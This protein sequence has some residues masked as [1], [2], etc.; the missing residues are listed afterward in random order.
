[1]DVPSGVARFAEFELDAGRYEL[2][3]GDRVLKLE[4]IPMQL[5]TLLVEGNGQLVTRDQIIE[6]IWGKGV[7]LDTEHG[8][9]TAIRKIRLALGDNPEQPRFVQTVTGK[10]YRFI[11]PTIEI[12][13]GG[14]G[15]A[16]GADSP[17]PV[18][19]PDAIG[20]SPVLERRSRWPHSWLLVLGCALALSFVANFVWRRAHAV[21]SSNAGHVDRLSRPQIKSLAVLP[22][23]NLSGDPS[24]EYFADGMTDELIT[25]LAKNS[26]LR[27]V[28][29]TSVMQY[30]GAHRP[31]PEIARALGVDGILEGSVVRSADRVHMTVQLIQAPSDTHVWAESYDRSGNDSVSIPQEAAQ[32][33]AKRL[34]SAVLQPT[35]QRFVLPDAHDA[36]LRG[37]YLWFMSKNE[38]A[39][40]YFR[41]AIELQPDYALGWAGVSTYYAAA[42]MTATLRPDEEA[43]GQTE[44]AA[45][46]AVE[47]DDSLPEGHLALGGAYFLRWNWAL[48]EREV[49][50]AIALNPQF[51]EAYHLQ[52]LLYGVLGRPQDGIEA[53]KRSTELDPVE[54]PYAMAQAYAIA[55]DYDAALNDVRVRLRGLPQDYELHW[56]LHE[57]YRRTGREKETVQELEKM[58][59]LSGE[60]ASSA[61][62]RRS[63]E[64]GGYKAVLQWQ[65]NDLKQKSSTR[66]V[67]PVLLAD[68]YAQLGRRQESLAFVEEAYRQR[69][70]LLVFI[71]NNPAFD[72]L[73]SDDR[74]RAIV[75][76]IGLPP[77]Y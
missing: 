37:R 40:E 3:R 59:Q 12:S 24:Q 11:A 42:V 62:V 44:A 60:E 18:D 20:S 26:T 52:S 10:G 49:A 31:L 45:H 58:L 65:V 14:N 77:A 68:L 57:I 8:I 47:L 35:P 61:S 4:G 73:H 32:T 9:N 36:Y 75:R 43:V 28:S 66:Y 1:L 55:R 6:R 13:E 34:N 33:I 21:S 72:F 41:R 23:D 67:T 71:Q 51:A 25:L 46:R 39:G 54:R 27:V 22:L 19:A 15:S 7:F 29:R 50:R 64:N 30:K 56:M 17:S 70:P 76:G 63:F 53:Q 38:E 69:A 16:T 74:Y 2:R 5:L 48:A